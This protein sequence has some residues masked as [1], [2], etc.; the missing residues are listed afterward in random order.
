VAL[1]WITLVLPLCYRCSTVVLP[2]FYRCFIGVSPS[3]IPCAA[4][5]IPWGFRQHYR[6]C[7]KAALPFDS[8][9]STIIQINSR[10]STPICGRLIFVVL[11]PLPVI[12][13]F[14]HDRHAT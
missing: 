6:V 10:L 13:S 2:L 4:T 11:L 1:H 9:G 14:S 7:T 8:A 12:Q 3:F 5:G